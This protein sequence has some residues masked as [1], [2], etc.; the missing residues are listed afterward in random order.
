MVD[1]ARS[2]FGIHSPSRLMRD[3]VGVYL[4]EGLM[5]G[6]NDKATMGQG[7][8]ELS[9][10]LTDAAR[11]AGSGM[12]D[13]MSNTARKIED[14]FRGM[15]LDLAGGVAIGTS[16]SQVGSQ[17]ST[18][19]AYSQP[20]N[21]NYPAGSQKGSGGVT[22]SGPLVAVNNMQVRNDQDIRELSNQLSRDIN[23]ELR[24]QGVLSLSLIHI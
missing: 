12:V 2:A 4:A 24:A 1:S 19:T 13:E 21:P 20:V 18:G 6:F 22:F 14:T 11:G 10:N 17:L 3:E 7:A 16:Y 8:E 5:V 15:N 23:R 9:R